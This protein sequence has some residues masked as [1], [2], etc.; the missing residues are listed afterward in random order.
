[1]QPDT[2]AVRLNLEGD[3]FRLVEAWRRQQSK[4]P[5]RGAAVRRLLE[6]ALTTSEARA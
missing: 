6:L 3:L 1:M 5:S 2:A 4:I